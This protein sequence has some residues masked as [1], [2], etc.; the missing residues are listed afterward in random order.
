MSNLPKTFI[1]TTTPVALVQ[2]LDVRGLLL[3]AV[4]EAT[5]SN[6]NVIVPVFKG[7]LPFVSSVNH[8]RLQARGHVLQVQ[9]H[10]NVALEILM[11]CG[12]SSL[13]WTPWFSHQV[14][15]PRDPG[16]Y[17]HVNF[18]RVMLMPRRTKCYGHAYAFSGQVHPLEEKTPEEISNLYTE[19]STIFALEHGPNMCLENDYD[20][21]REY[22]SEH[23]DDERQFGQ[24]HDVYCW[25]SGPASRQGVFRVRAVKGKVPSELHPLCADPAKADKT[26]ELFSINLPAGL[27]VMRGRQFQQNYSHEFPQCQWGL[28]KRLLA[29]AARLWPDFP[30]D[31]PN[32]EK[33]ASQ[34][35]L[36]QAAWL[37]ENRDKVRTALRKGTL[38]KKRRVQGND[39]SDFDEW[40]LDRTSYTLR[41]FSGVMVPGQKRTRTKE[42]KPTTDPETEPDTKASKTE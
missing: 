24:L 5:A 40:C 2:P 7:T 21:G 16:G 8:P 11:P 35:T 15:P 9:N 42:S 38:S 37:K 19:T 30:K 6:P 22:I 1:H 17:Q 25:I 34:A 4:K 29:D 33:G 14:Q 27:Y 13:I 10:F 31:V 23:S 20:N 32:D 28:F 3:R 36:I 26:R 12:Q 41:Q 39:V 18:G